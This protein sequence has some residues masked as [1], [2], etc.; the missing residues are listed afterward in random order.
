M[1]KTLIL[2]VD[3]TLTDSAVYYDPDTNISKR[4]NAKDGPGILCARK[5]GIDIIAVSSCDSDAVNRALNDLGVSDIQNNIKNKIDWLKTWQ[6]E[7]KQPLSDIGYIGDDFDDLSAMM[8][9]GFAACPADASE[10]VKAIVDYI[11]PVNGGEGA[12]RDV[13][14]WYLKKNGEWYGLI[15]NIIF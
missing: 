3:G 12:V 15:K 8:L 13:I 14:E 10:D 9:C 1:I 7:N 4:F 2:D 11:S 6:S 5:A